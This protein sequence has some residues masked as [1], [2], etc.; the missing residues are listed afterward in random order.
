MSLSRRCLCP[1]ALLILVVPFAPGCHREQPY[2]VVEGVVTV[3]GK[4]VKM[5]EVTFLPD[6]DKGTQGR[7][8]IAVTDDQGHYRITSD[9][10]RAGAP[11]GFHRVIVKDL[12]TGTPGV[13]TPEIAQPDEGGSSKAPAGSKAPPAAEGSNQKKARFPGIYTSANSTP[14]RDIEVKEGQQELNFDLKSN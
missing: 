11:V 1:L 10:G 4:P 7:R 12:L 9:E 3:D 13:F 8:S 6:P 5:T 14:F 2:G